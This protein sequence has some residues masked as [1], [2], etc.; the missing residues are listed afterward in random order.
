[1]FEISKIYDIGFIGVCGKTHILCEDFI[2]PRSIFLRSAFLRVKQ[3]KSTQSAT[4][5]KDTDQLITEWINDTKISFY[6][7]KYLEYP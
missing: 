5:L 4:G 1:M 2:L 6:K 7:I 3:K